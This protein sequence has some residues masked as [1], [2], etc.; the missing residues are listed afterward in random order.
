MGREIAPIL[1]C[2]AENFETLS[3]HER[4]FQEQPKLLLDALSIQNGMNIA[5]VGAGTGFLTVHLAH[6]VGP[7]GFVFATDVQSQMLD[8]LLSRPDLP[9]N[10]IP[11]LST[12]T[13]TG[14]PSKTFDLILL[15]DV[16]HEALRPDL[17]LKDLRRAL[18][19]NGRLALVEY[20]ME[21][22]R[23]TCDPR[24]KMSARQVIM[25]LE[26]NRFRL[27]ELYEHLPW[28]H[29]LIFMKQ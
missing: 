9:D 16:Y 1:L 11:I 22:P 17:L 6:R 2:N 27:V 29:I 12:P 26:A 14:L 8:A 21:D 3:R 7:Q 23:I 28:Q 19:S 24:H 20:R 25:E 5:D 15:V 13:D 10:V 18:K 4:W